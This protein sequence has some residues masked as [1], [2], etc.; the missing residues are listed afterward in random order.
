MLFRSSAEEIIA[1]E[2]QG[3]R[4]AK[5]EEKYASNISYKDGVTPEQVAEWVKGGRVKGT[6]SATK[7]TA[8]KKTGG[9]FKQ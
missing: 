4:L 2:K 9:L 1:G 8:A 6:A 5:V 7:P 3:E